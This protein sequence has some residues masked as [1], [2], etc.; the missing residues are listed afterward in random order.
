MLQAIN[1]HEV[2]ANL[3]DPFL[4]LQDGLLV[5]CNEAAVRIFE[6]DSKDEIL[7]VHPSLLSPPYQYGNRPSAEAADE[8]ISLALEKGAHRFEW[9]HQTINGRV[10][11]VEIS[12][13]VV[14]GGDNPLVSVQFHDISERKRSEIALEAATRKA[15]LNELKAV[16]AG[17]A[18]SEFLANMSHEIRTPMNG[19]IGMTDL[20]MDTELNLEQMKFVKIFAQQR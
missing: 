5:E 15:Q 8:M 7:N 13:G 2:F 18:K 1:F 19:V 11:P 14:H 4:F 10:F 20:L 6:A 9:E 3:E 16:D 12:L 17:K